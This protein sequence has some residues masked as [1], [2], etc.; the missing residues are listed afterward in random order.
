MIE[1]NACAEMARVA[2][3]IAVAHPDPREFLVEFGLR[4]AGIG[5]GRFPVLGLLSG[6]RNRLRGAGFR[7]ELRDRTAGQARHFAGVARSVTVIGLSR[8]RWVS[9]HVR[10][11]TPDS[12]DGRLTELAIEF[13]EL[14]LD[15]ALA[16]RDAGEWIR[17]RVCE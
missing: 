8:T 10:R 15:G 4:V 14:L 5:R 3:S 7:T 12:P 6:G 2:D 17:T 9:V 1:C 13:A 16:T 11:D